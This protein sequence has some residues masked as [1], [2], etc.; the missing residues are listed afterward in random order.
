M[1]G[2]AMM[3]SIICPVYNVE[4]FIHESIQSILQQSYT[5]FEFLII[6][7]CSNDNTLFEI[8]KINDPRIV[9]IENSKNIGPA[10]SLNVGLK[11]AIG[12]YIAIMHGDDIALSNR[13]S[14]QVLFMEKNI[15]IDILGSNYEMINEFG[16]SIGSKKINSENIDERLLFHNVLCHPTIMYR[17]TIFKSF[18]LSYTE[19]MRLNE[20]YDLFT[21]CVVKNRKISIVPKVLMKYRLHKSQQSFVKSKEEF[22]NFCEIRREFWNVK[23][24]EM[25]YILDFYEHENVSKLKL[26][27]KNKKHWS[28]TIDNFLIQKLHKI[29][30]SNKKVNITLTEYLSFTL[31]T[32]FNFFSF[33]TLFRYFFK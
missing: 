12:S 2:K 23:I 28:R 10:S 30:K 19:G 21:R 1:S 20:D 15:E 33:K 32:R 29:V 31:K 5:N 24:P 22:K 4:H 27:F 8:R 7:D 26:Y 17:S 16:K 13:I 9:L 25:K 3:V 14:E 6:D 11:K 18:D